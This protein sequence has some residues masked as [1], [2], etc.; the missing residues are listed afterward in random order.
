MK[1][2]RKKLVEEITAK[3]PPESY[4]FKETAHG[5]QD[6]EPLDLKDI[7]WSCFQNPKRKSHSYYHVKS[8]YYPKDVSK[9]NPDYIINLIQQ[10]FPAAFEIFKEKKIRLHDV[11]YL[12]N[13]EENMRGLQ[14]I[15]KKVFL[16]TIKK[17]TWHGPFQLVEGLFEFL[18]LENDSG[19][20]HN[21]YN[22]SLSLTLD[23]PKFPV[24][25][26][27]SYSSNQNRTSKRAAPGILI[28]K[29]D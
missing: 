10:V 13:T 8:L 1:L 25:I 9:D 2:C 12:W 29:Q 11:G 6:D 20:G 4:N 19:E 28:I 22:V 17:C 5:L 23:P 3:F 18:S 26:L 16:E 21:L 14:E 15:D 27:L 7:I 24:K